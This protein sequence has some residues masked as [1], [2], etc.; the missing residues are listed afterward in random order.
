MRVLLFG[1]FD[2]L[3]PGHQFLLTEAAKRGELTV[4]IARDVT[5]R[6][7]KGKLPIQSEQERQAAVSCAA[8]SAH[9]ILGDTD[10]YLR[11]IR[12][13]VPDLILLGYDQMLPDGVCMEDLPCSVERLPSF[14]PE[15]YKSSLQWKE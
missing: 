15:R 4:V 7:H 3:H 13:C 12:E 14:H 8:P 1:T 9:V 5:V 6:S 10:D 2:R 11:P